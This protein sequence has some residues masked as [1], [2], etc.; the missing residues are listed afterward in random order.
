MRTGTK[1]LGQMVL[2][3]ALLFSWCAA[4]WAQYQAVPRGEEEAPERDT[5]SDAVDLKHYRKGNLEWYTQELIASGL[6]ALHKEHIEILDALGRMQAR[7]ER[8]EKE[9]GTPKRDE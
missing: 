3:A 5:F 2:G 7:L 8:M 9:I 6:T 4:G 1:R